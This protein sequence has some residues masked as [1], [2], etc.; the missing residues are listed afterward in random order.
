MN[1]QSVPTR[2]PDGLGLADALF[3]NGEL[4]IKDWSY[5][6][7]ICSVFFYQLEYNLEEYIK[8]LE[9]F[10]S[11]SKFISRATVL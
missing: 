4:K 1:L 11:S 8:K 10:E 7:L 5:Y 2:K 3:F 9:C 6:V